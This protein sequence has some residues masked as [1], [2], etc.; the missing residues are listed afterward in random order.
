MAIRTTAFT[1]TL[2]LA[3]GI[4]LGLLAGHV[5]PMAEARDTVAAEIVTNTKDGRVSVMIHGKEIV[6][7]DKG[8]LH[9]DGDLK[10]S[11]GQV[12]TDKT[13]ALWSNPE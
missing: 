8:G 2:T 6:R 5:I 7:I 13:D 4:L 9:L 10:Y 3:I 11:G 12:D 1:L